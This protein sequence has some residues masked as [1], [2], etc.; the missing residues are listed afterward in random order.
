MEAFLDQSQVCIDYHKGL[1][2]KVCRSHVDLDYVCTT[3]CAHALIVKLQLV[4]SLDPL[5]LM[6]NCLCTTLHTLRTWLVYPDN[7]SNSRWAFQSFVDPQASTPGSSY[8]FFDQELVA[9][10]NR[11]YLE[12]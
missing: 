9:T 4:H 5:E 8:L 6:L 1:L 7:A 3:F 11:G 2:R 12:Y 10:R